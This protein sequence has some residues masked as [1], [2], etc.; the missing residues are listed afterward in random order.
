MKGR[1]AA[2]IPWKLFEV[3]ICCILHPF[4]CIN[5]IVV[6]LC[7]LLSYAH[8]EFMLSLFT[9]KIASSQ[10]VMIARRMCA[11]CVL[12]IHLT[13]H[14]RISDDRRG[15]G[16]SEQSQDERTCI[17]EKPLGSTLIFKYSNLSLCTSNLWVWTSLPPQR[18]IRTQKT[19][20]TNLMFPFCNFCLFVSE[21]SFLL[22]GLAGACDV[23]C[24]NLKGCKWKSELP[25]GNCEVGESKIQ[26]EN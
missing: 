15:G 7:M 21:Y 4:L 9:V 5:V 17:S 18:L 1:Y 3:R 25:H 23:N 11:F 10:I 2:V 16:N 20:L 12:Q 14:R 13:I 8:V 6:L 22:L 24:F 19:P 26:V